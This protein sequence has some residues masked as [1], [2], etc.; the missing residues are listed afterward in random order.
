MTDF[1]YD[2]CFSV[3]IANLKSRAD[4]R[5]HIVDQFADR[6]EF[7]IQII[8][9][10]KHEVG[11]VIDNSTLISFLLEYSK[12]QNIYIGEY[13]CGIFSR[14]DYISVENRSFGEY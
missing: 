14:A 3:F 10:V 5:R 4:R 2:H 8:E 6:K 13:C 7:E 1:F 9:P 12:C 11:A